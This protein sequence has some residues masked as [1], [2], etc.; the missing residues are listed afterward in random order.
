[1]LRSDEKNIMHSQLSE[2]SP[3]EDKHP[4]PAPAVRSPQSTS[5]FFYNCLLSLLV[6]LTLPFAAIAL[7]ARPRYRLGL[8]QRLGVVPRSVLQSLADHT[9][10]PLLWLHA[11]SVG[12]ILATQPFLRALKT[13]YPE[14]RL[15]LSVLTPTAYT[16]ATAKLPE[17]DEVIYLPFDHPLLIKRVLGQLKPAIFFFTE[18][19]LWPNWLLTLAENEVPTVLVSGRFSSRAVGRYRLFGSVFQPVLRSLR[20]CCMQTQQDA[21]RLIAT[22]ALP[23]RVCVTGNFKL[24][25]EAPQGDLGQ[26]VLRQLGLADRL[27][28][29]AASTHQGEEDILLAAYKELRSAIP[30]LLLLL[31]P[32]HPQR[33][34]RVEAL[35]QTGGYSYIKRSQSGGAAVPNTSTVEVLLLDSLGE[36]S[37]FYPSAALAF[38]GGSFIKG[39]G[40]HSVIEPAL[41]RIPVIFGPYTRNFTSVVETL[42]HHGGGIEVVDVESFCRA[43]LP[44]LADAS[45]RRQVG[46]NAYQAIH[47]D[48]GAVDR[49]LAAILH[50]RHVPTQENAAGHRAVL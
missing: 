34:A 36:L 26:A 14:A 50:S 32:R 29:V 13:H 5:L 23:A 49:T 22:G 24:D 37:S 44:L 39:P 1:M 19:E 28:L 8:A 17:A 7:L 6:C 2:D 12:E 47:P 45:V 48:Q 41:A 33:F 42:K 27:L 16:A 18:T 10:Q 30:Q 25:A 40:G 3:A 31:A 15:L 35:L 9:H 43:T 11:P 46:Y 4:H 20:L 21:E 38:V